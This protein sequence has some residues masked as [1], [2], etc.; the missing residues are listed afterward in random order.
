MFELFQVAISPHQILL[1]LLLA[2]VVF[3]WLLVVLGALDF[4]TDLPD[5]MDGDADTH[6]HHGVNTSGAWITAGRFFGFSQ[7]PIVVWLSFMVLFMWFFSLVLNQ[8]WNPEDGTPRALLLLL[9]NMV[10]SLAATKLVTIPVAKLFKA[11]TD[12][13]TEA[14]EVIGRTGVVASIEVDERYGQLEITAKGAPL[15]INVRVEPGGVPITKGTAAKVTAAG[16]DSAYYFIEA[17]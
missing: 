7:V 3:Y 15:L 4:E 11:M 6:A 16:P 2:L 8:K 13:D 5:S 9:P 1:T 12:A 14:E 10:A 17:V